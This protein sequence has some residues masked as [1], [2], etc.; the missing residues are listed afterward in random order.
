[1][2]RAW[3]F[4]FMLVLINLGFVS[5]TEPTY[6]DGV[7]TLLKSDNFDVDDNYPSRFDNRVGQ[8]WYLLV[9]RYNS[10][11]FQII[12][13]RGGSGYAFRANYSGVAQQ[14]IPIYTYFSAMGPGFQDYGNN[15]LCFSLYI[16][17]TPGWFFGS[18]F[19]EMWLYGEP[20]R[21]QTG[22]AAKNWSVQWSSNPDGPPASD[23]FA[24]QPAWSPHWDTVND[25]NWHKFTWCYKK[26]SA[27]RANDGLLRMYINSTRVL[28][29]SETG[30]ADG[31]STET[32]RTYLPEYNIRTLQFPD[33]WVVGGNP[34]QI[35]YDDFVIWVEFG[36]ANDTTPPVRSS[37]LPVGLFPFNTTQ[38]ILS[39]QTKKFSSQLTRKLS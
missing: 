26:P 8:S 24:T 19:M 28:D 22:G 12:P 17:A 4:L 36:D 20:G 3:L 30:V 15:T 31:Y 33:V 37:G 29:I 18:K 2:K 10:S 16:R 34:G 38:A 14:A 7:D 32:E 9:D 35:D 5:A 23:P 21:I 39:L 6:N 13:G 1:M 25:G 27:H 11:T